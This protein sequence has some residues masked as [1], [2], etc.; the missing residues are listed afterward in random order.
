M[1]LKDGFYAS[2]HGIGGLML[3]MPT[4]NPKTREKPKFKVG[5]MVRCEAE[6]FI[7]PFRGYVEHVYN[8]SA[9]IR[10]E[11][12]MKCDRS[13]AKHKHYLAV[14]R[15]VDIELINDK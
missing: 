3:D 13:T 10:I 7:Y 5:D 15:L 4:K 14:A 12:T 2:S 9:I 11:N 6:E 1:K 8:H